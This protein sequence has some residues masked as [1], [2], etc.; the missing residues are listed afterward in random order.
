MDIKDCLKIL[1]NRE[2]CE[3]C[4]SNSNGNGNGNNPINHASSCLKSRCHEIKNIEK[5]E[6]NSLSMNKSLV[7]KDDEENGE[8]E[9]D[10]EENLLNTYSTLDLLNLITTIQGE[11]V[12]KFKEY[13][14]NL[15]ILLDNNRLG[16]Y[17]L[18]CA[19][20]TAIFA[21]LSKSVISIRDIL[22]KRNHDFNDNKNG[23][24]NESNVVISLIN[25]LQNLEKEKLT[26]VAANH[27]DIIQNFADIFQFNNGFTLSKSKS[28]MNTNKLIKNIEI[29]IS[30]IIEEINAEKST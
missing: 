6:I 29:K 30:E 15:Q 13:D 17:P 1:S 19:E 9:E 12:I 25:N 24:K 4:D 28:N 3:Y 22:L 20:M 5:E 10:E 16:E 21:T 23:N 27:I 2:S 8:E 11:R 26:L 18:L 14:D 7:S